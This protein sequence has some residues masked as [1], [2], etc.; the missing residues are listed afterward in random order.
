MKKVNLRFCDIKEK[1]PERILER[2]RKKVFEEVNLYPK[3]Y[4]MLIAKLA[5]KHGIKRENIVLTN[6][7]DG[8]IELLARTFGEKTLVFTPTY[9]E[10]FDA[11]RRNGLKVTAISALHGKSFKPEASGSQLRNSSLIYLC[12]PN[13]PLGLLDSK[14]I[15]S[16]AK[17][18]RGIVALDETYIDFAGKSAVPLIRKFKNLLVLRGFSKGYALAGLRIG[19]I[20]GGKALMEKIRAKTGLGIYPVASVSVNAAAIALGEEGYFDRMRKETIERKERFEK[21][22]KGMGFNVFPTQTNISLIK[23]PSIRGA[24]RLVRYLEKKGILV[25]QGDGVST[26]GLD[27]RW[28]R[29]ACGTEDEMG[30]VTNIIKKYRGGF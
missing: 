14:T 23:L 25:N 17:S 10:F 15:T 13:M 6:G 11:P 30:Y 3:N 22:L 8:G 5:R 19:Y 29:F 9:Y 4:D 7:V 24:N 26:C 16:I 18:T 1:L 20:I 12:N 27:R 28:I 2:F 21:V